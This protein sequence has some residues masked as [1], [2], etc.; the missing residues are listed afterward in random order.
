MSWLEK[1]QNKP[2]GVK[3][4]IVWV[5]SIITVVLL[6]IVWV[7]SYRF[8]KTQPPDTSLFQSIGQDIHNVKTNYG[9]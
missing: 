9:K 1:I 8:E 5:I 2:T 6:I 7:I 3:I 4:K